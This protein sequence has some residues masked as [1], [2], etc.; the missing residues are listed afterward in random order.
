MSVED[1]VRMIY[2]RNLVA[3]NDFYVWGVEEGDGGLVDDSCSDNRASF[4]VE[5]DVNGDM[6]SL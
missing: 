6:R 4:V 3:Y 5:N 2:S 1:T